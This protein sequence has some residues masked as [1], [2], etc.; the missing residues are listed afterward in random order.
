MNVDTFSKKYTVCDTTG[1]WLW[2]G[3]INPNGYACCAVKGRKPYR[4]SAHVISW[5]VHRG[6]VPEGA[7]I[8]H[9]C[10]V[11]HCV[12]PD[13]LEPVTPKE[14]INRG[15]TAKANLEKTH[16]P[17]GHEY[18]EE[19]TRYKKARSGNLRRDCKAC[20]RK[21]ALERY[22]RNKTNQQVGD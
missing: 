17:H 16:C 19:N 11:R 20:D 22:H 2:K 7:V 15:D 5:E 8:D 12:N 1:C 13:H 10:K 9:L 21:R 4:T 6:P 18:N 14:N 3:F